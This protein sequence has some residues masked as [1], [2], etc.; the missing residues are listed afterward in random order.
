ML[1]VGS[2]HLRYVNDPSDQAGAWTITKAAKPE[3]LRLV[4]SVLVEPDG[5]RRKLTQSE[6]DLVLS[7]LLSCTLASV[8][9]PHSLR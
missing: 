2:V 5:S 4:Q 8:G 6:I 1:A 3:V 9:G 7:A